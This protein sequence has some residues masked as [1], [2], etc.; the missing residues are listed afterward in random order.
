MEATK[1]CRARQPALPGER[2]EERHLPPSRTGGGERRPAS[3][4]Q[5]QMSGA[6]NPRSTRSGEESSFFGG[7]EAAETYSRASI[8][9]G[10][11]RWK[12]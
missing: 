3:T 11:D 6:S 2:H 7:C 1:T 8:W 5:D 10:I 4:V 12:S 9:R